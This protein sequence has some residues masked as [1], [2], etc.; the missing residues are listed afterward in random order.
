[1]TFAHRNF[2]WYRKSVEGSLRWVCQLVRP[3][4]IAA[5]FANRTAS[6]SASRPHS[7]IPVN[8]TNPVDLAAATALWQSETAR[9]NG[10]TTKAAG[11]LAAQ[12]LVVAGLAAMTESSGFSRAIVLAATAYL[13]CALVAAVLAQLPRPLMTIL[14]ADLQSGS[15][16]EAMLAVTEANELAGTQLS[17]LVT[18][19]VCDTARSLGL[20]LLAVVAAVVS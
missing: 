2:A 14:R 16:A 5:I 10:L 18:A 12:A 6:R 17:N 7:S 1:M 20:L 3:T 19:S 8:P 15:T 11:I 4:L 9:I 13:G